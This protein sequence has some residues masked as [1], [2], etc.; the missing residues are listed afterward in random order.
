MN[1][2]PQHLILLT[3]MFKTLK[4]GRSAKFSNEAIEACTGTTKPSRLIK[5]LRDLGV[6]IERGLDGNKAFYVLTVK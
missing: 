2:T 6:E 3:A 5:K 4:K 1:D